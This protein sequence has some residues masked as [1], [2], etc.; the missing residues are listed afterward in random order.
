M[1]EFLTVDEAAEI[2]RVARSTI[3]RYIKAKEIRSVKLQK[4]RLIPREAI[5]E[6]VNRH[7][8]GAHA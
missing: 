7:M 8:E 3:D 5:N 1:N 6:F 4:R 2:L